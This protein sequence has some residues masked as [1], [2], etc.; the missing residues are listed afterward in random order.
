MT[1][2]VLNNDLDPDG[3]MLS[4]LFLDG[5]PIGSP[6][7]TDY[8]VVM[9]DADGTYTFTPNP[10]FFGV[11][12]FT[13]TVV[14]S[15]GNMETSTVEIVVNNAEIGVA[16]AA[17]DPVPNGDNFDVAFTLVVENLGSLDLANLTLT[18]DVAAMFGNAFVSAGVPVVQNFSGSGI[19]P[20]VNASWAGDT[21]QNILTDG[22]LAVGESFEVVFTV[23]V[24]PDADG[25]IQG[26][27]NQAEAV[28]LAVNP[29]GSPVLDANGDPAFASDLS[30]DGSD[31]VGENGSDD[32]DG[33]FGNDVTPIQIADL[34]IAKTI[35][36]E[37][38]LL[39][40]GNYVVTYQVIVENTGTVALTDI[41][42]L[43]DLSSQFGSAFVN[44]S[45][46]SL[47]VGPSNLDSNISVDPAFDGDTNIELLS[48]ASANTLAVGDSFTLELTVEVDP[49]AVTGSVG[50]QVS[51]SG[52]GVDAD[53]NPLLDS[54]GN[55][56]I[57]SDL[58]DSGSDPGGTNPGNPDDTG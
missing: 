39:F 12:T 5:Q 14:D 56:V 3:D 31:P 28:G 42:L 41:S 36:G 2:N 49:L 29:D 45:G 26:L 34:G 6:I 20:Q 15:A 19:P 50:N 1:G 21:S 32:G 43:E 44:A 13:Y 24:D 22:T 58:S 23:T 37:P 16:K 48:Q 25:V 35:V 11:D 47:I 53:G 9:I 27:S 4:V 55:P 17:S 54:A 33:V 52:A 10:G 30:D 57:G 38:D 8:G 18:D 51:G 40:S 7:V 46:L